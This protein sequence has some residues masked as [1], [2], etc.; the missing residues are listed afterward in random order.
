M[1]TCDLTPM[2]PPDYLV[3][4]KDLID[5]YLESYLP[6]VEQYPGRLHEAI[7]YSVMAGGKR[8]RPI[9][10][11]AAYETCG[12]TD[13]TIYPAAVA[14][15]FI[16]T[17]SLIHDDLPCMDDDD[18]RRGQPTCHKKFGEAVALLA[19]DALH[20]LAFNLVARTGNSQVVL[21]LAEAIGTKGMLAG[22]MAD[23]E[24][25]GR[26]ISLEEIN[27]IHAHKTGKLIRGSVR[28]GAVLADAGEDK[29]EII[30]QYGEKT[31]LA[32]QIIDD[33]LDIIG[34]EKTLGKS[35]GSDY[36]NEK[37]TFPGVIGLEPSRQA[38]NKLIKEAIEVISEIV[39]IPENLVQ[40]ARYIGSRQQ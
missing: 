22:Q 27:F 40:I 26:Q 3:E 19:G 36:K 2:A 21:E 8:L 5:R 30:S 20:D 4:K 9:L 35:I 18:L 1:R 25:E 23:M 11:L 15:E 34:D 17:Y 31:G 29:L 32:F 13:Q 6:P 16:H 24:A 14:I 37:A 39:P 12:G 10:A 38:A 28:I 33:I 7:R